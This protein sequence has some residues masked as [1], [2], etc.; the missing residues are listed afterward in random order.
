MVLKI[1]PNLNSTPVWR[2]TFGDMPGGVGMFAPGGVPLQD[3]GHTAVY[4]EC[5]S[6]A[7]IP[8]G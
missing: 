5:W 4:T 8:T 7:S 6:I 2:T 1:A 3:I